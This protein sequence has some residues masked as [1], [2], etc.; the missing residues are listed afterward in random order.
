MTIANWCVL[1]ACLL[2]IITVGL[3]KAGSA[4]SATRA[5][6]YDNNN[7]REWATRLTGWQQRALAAQ[8]NGWE[9]LPLFIAAV[10][11]AQQ[12]HADQGR[13]D[14]LAMSF[15]GIRIAYVIVYLMNI[16]PLRSL[17]WAAGIGT[18]IAILLMA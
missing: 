5:E 16:G 10:V 4:T 1:T 8:N 15:I 14:L 7:P 18:S 12:A 11:L 6:R 9:A 3:A 17:I 2:P 13:I